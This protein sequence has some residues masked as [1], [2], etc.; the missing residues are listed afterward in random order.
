MLKKVSKDK[1]E[2]RKALI[3][4]LNLSSQVQVVER[5]LEGEIVTEIIPGQE[6]PTVKLSDKD[7]QRRAPAF[8]LAQRFVEKYGRLRPQVDPLYAEYEVLEFAKRLRQVWAYTEKHQFRTA[9]SILLEIL[10]AGNP[11]TN[12]GQAF[13]PELS[14]ESGNISFKPATRLH[15]LAVELLQSRRA[16]KRCPVCKSFF[17]PSK[18]NRRKYC[19]NPLRDCQH[20]ARNRKQVI[21]THNWRIRE[22]QRKEST[23]AKRSNRQN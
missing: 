21:N 23:D 16:L 12:E 19:E 2:I 20:E 7:D 15:S 14:A 9:E 10:R 3:E 6:W 18:G 5:G 4:L 17:F 22:E 13:L 1:R 8:S 11:V